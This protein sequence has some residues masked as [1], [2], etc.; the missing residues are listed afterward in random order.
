MDFS[1]IEDSVRTTLDDKS[2][3]DKLWLQADILEYA[4][5]AENEACERADL[6]VDNTSSL[7]DIAVNTS[8]GT[9]GLSV[10]VIAIKSAIMASGTRPLMETSEEVLDN[11]EPGWRTATGTPR[12]YIKT[13]TNN[14]ILYPM[15]TA[16]DTINMTVSRFPNTPMS[17]AGSP[18]IDARYHAGMLEWILHRAYMKNDSETLNVGKAKDHKKKFVETFGE[19]KILSD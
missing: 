11:T 6:I 19:K 1:Q 12:S 4:R 5:D 9:Y 2:N 14:I 16:A 10:T 18:E 17:I 15:P 7:T 13:P 3:I 8:T